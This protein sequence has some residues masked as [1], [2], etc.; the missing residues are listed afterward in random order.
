[1]KRFEIVEGIGQGCGLSMVVA[2]FSLTAAVTI[3]QFNPSEDLEE[4]CH[5]VVPTALLIGVVGG[6]GVLWSD[7]T[8]SEA[9]NKAIENIERLRWQRLKSDVG[10]EYCINSCQGCKHLVG[11]VG[12]SHLICAMHPYGWQGN[13][14]PD[15]EESCGLR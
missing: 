14:C 12:M 11:K 7:R 13:D 15:K 3:L 10:N 1:M 5:R 6:L 4:A 8:I 2:T 9:A